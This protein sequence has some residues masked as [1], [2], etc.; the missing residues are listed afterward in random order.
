MLSEGRVTELKEGLS[1][2]QD[3]A[4]DDRGIGG[5][6]GWPWESGAA[7]RERGG[8][9]EDEALAARERVVCV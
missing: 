5:G 1:P 2:A 9:R 7:W 4:E 6:G 8:E 3:G